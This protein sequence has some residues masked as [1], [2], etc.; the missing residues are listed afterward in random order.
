MRNGKSTK[1][2]KHSKEFIISNDKNKAKKLLELSRYEVSRYVSLVTDHGN[3]AYFLSKLEPGVNPVC[4]FCEE[5]NE[6]FIHLTEC[7]RLRDYQVDC[8]LGEN[9]AWEWNHENILKFSY[10]RAVNEAIEE[11]EMGNYSFMSNSTS[12]DSE[13]NFRYSLPESD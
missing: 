9:R 10:C 5:R 3:L 11:L 8:F 7:P 2:E 12:S 6:T 13:D 4:R 1:R